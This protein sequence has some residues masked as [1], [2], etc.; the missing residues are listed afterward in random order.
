MSKTKKL[1]KKFNAIVSQLSPDQVR[2]Q[3]VLAYIQMERCQQV[4]RGFDVKPVAM[5]DNGESSD[6]E[7]F[8]MCKKVREE[9]DY[10]NH[11]EK[12]KKGK[13]I[14]IGVDVDC[15]DAIKHFKELE[16]E[17]E[18]T[19][20]L[21]KKNSNP[22]PDV[23]VMKVDLKKFFKP[24]Q[25]DTSSPESM[26]AF[27]KM[28]C[29]CMSLV[30]QL[31]KNAIHPVY[32]M[33]K[34]RIHRNSSAKFIGVSEDWKLLCKIQGND[35]TFNEK[36][37]YEDPKELVCCIGNVVSN[38]VSLS[39]DHESAYFI[40]RTNRVFKAAKWY[41]EDQKIDHFDTIDELRK[42]LLENIIDDGT[43]KNNPIR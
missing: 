25:F 29:D 23:F 39:S 1:K 6:L 12:P 32:F 34:G 21:F 15:S 8:Y 24:I 13:S 27:Y 19:K 22:K 10:L 9:L 43:N 11:A 42:Y 18:Q 37:L 38:H 30:D 33:H 16:K 40:D 26:M 28:M 36:D 4:L 31:P 20:N 14:T 17:F 3:L 35:C 2:E 5:M 41:L 7:L